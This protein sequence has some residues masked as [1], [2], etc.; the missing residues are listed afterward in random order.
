MRINLYEFEGA[1]AMAFVFKN[2]K[3]Y[4]NENEA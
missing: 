1:K 4:I 2:K 3:R